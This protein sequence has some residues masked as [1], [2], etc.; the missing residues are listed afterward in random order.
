[1][2]GALKRIWAK[3]SH[4]SWDQ[5]GHWYRDNKGGG[6]EYIRADLARPRVKPLVWSGTDFLSKA[7]SSPGVWYHVCHMS[8]GRWKVKLWMK[9]APSPHFGD[10][11]YEVPH[12]GAHVYHD[13]PT[14][15]RAAAQADHE[16][17][18]WDN[19]E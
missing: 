19:L 17:R 6:T 11:S 10:G 13:S 14:A 12:P 1:M 8:N 16:R 4:D 15:G 5:C 9:G 7:Q 18:I 3:P 2:T